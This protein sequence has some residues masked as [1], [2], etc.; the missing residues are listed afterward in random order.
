MAA[1][2]VGLG[3]DACL[4]GEVVDGGLVGAVGS[5]ERG[6]YRWAGVGEVGQDGA[7]DP[8]VHAGE[9]AGRAPPA[10][11]IYPI[12]EPFRRRADVS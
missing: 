2:R 12:R 3:S 9:D 4:P 10:V 6:W 7:E 1:R 11:G 5:L 8:V